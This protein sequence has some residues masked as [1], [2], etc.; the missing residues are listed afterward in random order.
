MNR[1]SMVFDARGKE[2]AVGNHARY[3]DTGTI[4]EIVD[5]KTENGIDE[6]GNP[7]YSENYLIYNKQEVASYVDCMYNL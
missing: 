3:V 1:S 5:L 7:I 4:G 2:L 6:A